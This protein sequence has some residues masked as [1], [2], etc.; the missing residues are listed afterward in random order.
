M[1]LKFKE[2]KKDTF[3]Q[4]PKLSYLDVSNNPLNAFP[5]L[6][7]AYTIKEIKLSACN[8]TSL[9][10]RMFDDWSVKSEHLQIDLSNNDIQSI[11]KQALYAS[12]TTYIK[13]QRL[14]LNGYVSIIAFI[15]S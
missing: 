4:F 13:L 8:I 12:N 6:T 15:C 1:A 2:L 9:P 11:H 3:L 7:L 5:S 14:T 10:A